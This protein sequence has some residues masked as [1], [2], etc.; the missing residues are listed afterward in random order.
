M[1]NKMEQKK[2]TVL[3]G[4]VVV[5]TNAFVCRGRANR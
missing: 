4:K 5:K 2:K 1:M 3:L